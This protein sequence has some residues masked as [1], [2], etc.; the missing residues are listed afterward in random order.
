ME[1]IVPL[2]NSGFQLLGRKARYVCTSSAAEQGLRWGTEAGEGSDT[3]EEEWQRGREWQR[4]KGGWHKTQGTQ[5]PLFRPLC[6]RR[7]RRQDISRRLGLNDWCWGR[8]GKLEWE[9]SSC[10]IFPDLLFWSSLSILSPLYL[11][12]FHGDDL[13]NNLPYMNIQSNQHIFP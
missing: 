11:S 5:M 10:L 4:G 6:Y 3:G 12:R 13:S 7:R 9:M 1:Y 8:P 2:I